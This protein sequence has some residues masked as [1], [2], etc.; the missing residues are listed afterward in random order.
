MVDKELNLTIR[1]MKYTGPGEDLTEGIVAK[2]GNPG[3]AYRWSYQVD[4]PKLAHITDSVL[5]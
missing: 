4:D 2:E 3:T 5:I 1:P